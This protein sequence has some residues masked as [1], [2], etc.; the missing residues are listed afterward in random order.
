VKTA[1]RK[2]VATLLIASTATLSTSMQVYADVDVRSEAR[3][4][5][6]THGVNPADAER[7]VAALTDEES[8]QLATAIDELPAGGNPLILFI[9]AAVPIA[10][11]MMAVAV[12]LP[13]IL[14]GGI[15]ATAVKARRSPSPE[16]TPAVSAEN[17]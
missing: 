7:R 17:P 11:G 15:V 5:L 8:A 9:M 6:I 1:I 4:Q 10:V 2:T 12:A 13:I 14:V 16:P 3:A